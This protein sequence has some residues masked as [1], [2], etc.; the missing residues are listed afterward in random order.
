MTIEIGQKAPDL[1][2][3][4]DHG[5]TVTLSDY[6]GKYI[7]LYFYPKDMTPDAQLKHAIFGTATKASLNWMPLL[8]ASALTVRK[9]TENLKRSITFHFCFLLMTNISW[10][11]RL[12][13]GS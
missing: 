8:S 1:E 5:E 7:V 2:L 6:K 4:G 3:K 11:K 12:M 10:R 13:Y 9:N